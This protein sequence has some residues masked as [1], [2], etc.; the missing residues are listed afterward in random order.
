MQRKIIALLLLGKISVGIIM[1]TEDQ[2]IFDCFN[3][4]ESVCIYYFSVC[5]DWI[6]C[7]IPLSAPGCVWSLGGRHSLYVS[8][9][10]LESVIKGVRTSSNSRGWSRLSHCAQVTQMA[11]EDPKVLQGYPVLYCSIKLS[12]EFKGSFHAVWSPLPVTL[13]H[14]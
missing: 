13:K 4:A 1:L 12:K 10:F 11:E 6:M 5:R 2:G 14:R 9:C 3:C 7:A 8:F